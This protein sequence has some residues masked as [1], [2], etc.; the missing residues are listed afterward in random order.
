MTTWAFQL[1][2]LEKTASEHEHYA[3]DLLSKVAEPLKVL[4]T[5]LEQLRK[6]HGNV[7]TELEREWDVS[8]QELKKVKSKY[9]NVCQEVENKRKK[10]DATFEFE[11][12]KA[13]AAFQQHQEDMRNAKVRVFLLTERI[14]KILTNLRTHTF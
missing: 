8:H 6:V 5:E 10:Q 13:T 3:K 9:D 11:R 14:R 2:T 7:D 1:T 4:N 12:T